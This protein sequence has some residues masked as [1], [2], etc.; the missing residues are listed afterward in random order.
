MSFF[1]PN[2]VFFRYWSALFYFVIDLTIFSLNHRPG[3]KLICQN[4]VHCR[5]CPFRISSRTKST[6][7]FH[8]TASLILQWW[9]YSHFIQFCSNP[10][11]TVPAHFQIK[12]KPNNL[13]CIFIYDKMIFVLWVFLIP[14]SC[15]ASYKLPIFSFHI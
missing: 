11:R 15:K 5:N 1:N 4:T 14:V 10:L 13:C 3:I 6:V 12:N 2:P 7:I 9:Q 8:S